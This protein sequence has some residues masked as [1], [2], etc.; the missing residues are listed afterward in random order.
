MKKE[1]GKNK[2]QNKWKLQ[3]NKRERREIVSLEREKKTPY[4]E[5]CLMWPMD[6]IDGIFFLQ[7]VCVFLFLLFAFIH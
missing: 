2:Q 3:T 1:K 6:E 5:E 4:V 7:F